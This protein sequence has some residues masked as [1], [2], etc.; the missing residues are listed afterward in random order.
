[1]GLKWG[2]VLSWP[3]TQLQG[4]RLV[5]PRNHALCVCLVFFCFCFFTLQAHLLLSIAFT[6]SCVFS[7]IACY[8]LS[9]FH[10]PMFYLASIRLLRRETLPKL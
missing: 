2:P 10:F 8:L 5:S 6:S 4:R 1:M 9:V 3:V 7:P